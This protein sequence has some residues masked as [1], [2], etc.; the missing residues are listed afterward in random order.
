MWKAHVSKARRH[1]NTCEAQK[2]QSNKLTSH[3]SELHIWHYHFFTDV[4]QCFRFL[5]QVL[6]ARSFRNG[7]QELNGVAHQLRNEYPKHC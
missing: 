2:D 6:V 7:C 3:T 4:A 1:K 5:K